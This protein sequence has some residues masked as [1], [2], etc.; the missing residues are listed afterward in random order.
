MRALEE[1]KAAKEAEVARLRAELEGIDANTAESAE[2][3]RRVREQYEKKV[4]LVQGQLRKLQVEKS[5]GDELRADKEK[6]RS[7]AKVRELESEVTRMRAMQ[8]TLKRKLRDR[9]ERHVVAQE[10]QT[11]EIG[12]LKRQADAQNRRIRELVSDKEKQRAALRKDGRTRRRA[13]RV[14][15]PRRGRRVGIQ[16]DGWR[17]APRTWRGVAEPEIVQVAARRVQ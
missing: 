6:L 2:E 16:P 15:T 7:T 4:R 17:D 10:E 8:E 3:K 11:K 9:E 13:A 12:A 1:E 14:G 5:E